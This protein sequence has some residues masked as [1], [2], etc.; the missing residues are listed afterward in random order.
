[1]FNEYANQPTVLYL[2]AMS[3]V[4]VVYMPDDCN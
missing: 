1:M 2:E 3:Y 4:F